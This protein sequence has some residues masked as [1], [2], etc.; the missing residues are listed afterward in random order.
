MTTFLADPVIIDRVRFSWKKFS[1]SNDDLKSLCLEMSSQ[2][3]E[4]YCIREELD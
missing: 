4:S 1:M 2:V 3:G